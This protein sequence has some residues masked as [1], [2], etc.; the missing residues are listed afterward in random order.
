MTRTIIA[1]A[2][3]LTG[4][5]DSTDTGVATAALTCRTSDKTCTEDGRVC[6]IW[7]DRVQV[8]ADEPEPEVTACEGREGCTAVCWGAE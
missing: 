4:C 2:L 6:A 1:L 7:C 8:D 5:I 3:L